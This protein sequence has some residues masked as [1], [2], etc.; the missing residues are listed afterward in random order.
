[1]AEAATVQADLPV[2][3]RRVAQAAVIPRAVRAA[4]IPRTV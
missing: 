2:A 3:V 4:V 1:M